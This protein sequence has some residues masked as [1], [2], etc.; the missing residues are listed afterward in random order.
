MRRWLLLA[1]LACGLGLGGGRG[2]RDAPVRAASTPASGP[3]P[4]VPPRPYRAYVPVVTIAPPPA[5]SFPAQVIALTNQRRAAAG[6]RALNHSLELSAAASH[7]SQDMADHDFFSH[8]GSDGSTPEQRAAAAGYPGFLFGAENVAAGQATPEQVVAAWMASPGHR[9]NIL[10]CQFR[11]I[12]VGYAYDPA[13]RFGPY[14]HY[15]T[16]A[17]GLQ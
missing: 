16:Q 14:H 6:C 7:H 12:G 3:P 4:P 8:T 11:A 13:D 9:A 1:V 5:A 10:N 15:W 17:F 2:G